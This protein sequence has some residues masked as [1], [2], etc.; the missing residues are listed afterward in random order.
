[1][2]TSVA[3]GCLFALMSSSAFA[4][5]VLPAPY[6]PPVPPPVYPP[7]PPPAP[8]PYSWT[9]IYGGANVGWGFATI[10]DT[11]TISGG[12]LGGASASGSG[13]KNAI[14][15]GGQIGYNYQINQ[16]VLGVEGDFDYSGLSSSSSAGIVSQ[17]ANSQWLATA[18]VRAG[19]AIDRVMFYGTGGLAV[20]PVS[21]SL[22]AAGFS[23]Y[24]A[25]SDNLGWT[26]GAGVEGAVLQNV[27]VRIEYLYVRSSFTLSGPLSI[28][29]GTLSYAGTF[30][31][32]VV[33]AGVNF[34][35]P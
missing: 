25:S 21:D 27:T 11:G 34:K 30:S 33:R 32:N 16:F 23:I 20:V 18:R 1:M 6:P 3:L 29:G 5:D 22:T 2:R 14:L 17:T 8:P 19:Y 26:I 35:Y 9:G 13:S 24:S 28:V 10:T 12:L 31:E 7:P 4:A 15:G